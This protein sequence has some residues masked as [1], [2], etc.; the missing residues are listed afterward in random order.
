MYY[1]T[2][3]FA[4]HVIKPKECLYN[5]MAVFDTTIY[6]TTIDMAMLEI[7]GIYCM[8]RQIVN[9]RFLKDLICVIYY[10]RV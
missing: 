8:R 9:I 7:L 3:T 1:V 2:P 6:I 10:L 5:C 4:I